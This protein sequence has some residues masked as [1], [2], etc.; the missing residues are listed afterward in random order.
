[1][2]ISGYRAT[3]MLPLK[4]VPVVNQREILFSFHWQEAVAWQGWTVCQELIRQVRD[5][6]PLTYRFDS[7]LQNRRVAM[8]L[9]LR[10]ALAADGDAPAPWS[11]R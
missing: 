7:G 9:E 10:V 11:A 2:V 6:L 5:R 8:P 3:Q 4:R 1:V